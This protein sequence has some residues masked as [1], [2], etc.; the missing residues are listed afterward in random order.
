MTRSIILRTIIFISLYLMYTATANAVA[1]TSKDHKKGIDI[2][3]ITTDV[4]PA[5]TGAL[6]EMNVPE[7]TMRAISHKSHLM[8]IDELGKIHRFHK[9]RVKKVKKHHSKL[10]I[11]ATIIIVCCQIALLIHAFMHIS[12]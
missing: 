12:H 5:R 4:K 8:K 6:P 9:E 10:W 1:S 11:A 7:G 2:A 3:S